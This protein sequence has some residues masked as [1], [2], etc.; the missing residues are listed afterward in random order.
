MEQELLKAVNE[1]ENANFKSLDRVKEIYSNEEILDI[2]LMC[3]GIIGYTGRVL[4]V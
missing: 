1:M 4:P 2:W 3:E